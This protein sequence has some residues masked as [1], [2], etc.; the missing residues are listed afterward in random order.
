MS[1]NNLKSEIVPI[2]LITIIGIVSYYQAIKG[3]LVF[4]SLAEFIGVLMA[5]LFTAAVISLL[6]ITFKKKKDRKVERK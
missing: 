4:D 2:L 5:S 3:S 6:Y 1:V